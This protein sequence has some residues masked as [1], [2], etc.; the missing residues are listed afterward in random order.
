M[1]FSE[2]KGRAVVEING[3]KAI[4][5]LSDL[6]IDLQTR[7]VIG[8]RVKESGLFGKT[9]SIARNALQSVGQDALTVS[10]ANEPTANDTVLEK[11]PG[12]TDLIGRQVVSQGGKLVGD[13][14][15][16]DLDP[17]NLTVTGYEIKEGGLLGKKHHLPETS[18]LT[19]GPQMVVVPDALIEQGEQKSAD[20]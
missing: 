3:A 5:T 8:L 4:G 12:F 7:Q 20:K 9:N 10:M 18:D 19:F 11:G 1:K 15:D 6:V 14:S 16:I 2:L 17:N 13:I